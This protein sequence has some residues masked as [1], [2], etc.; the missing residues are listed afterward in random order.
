MITRTTTTTHALR[1]R[2]TTDLWHATQTRSIRQTAHAHTRTNMSDKVSSRA[3][4]RT[5]M[6]PS[7]LCGEARK[8]NRRKKNGTRSLPTHRVNELEDCWNVAVVRS[9]ILAEALETVKIHVSAAAGRRACVRRAAWVGNQPTKKY[10]ART[11]PCRRRW[12]R[13]CAAWR[14]LPWTPQILRPEIVVVPCSISLLCCPWRACSL[15]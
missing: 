9:N 14:S 1:S 13:F 3:L 12:A 5:W 15:R 10:S 8:E 11:C 6:N 7:P 4:P 2:Q